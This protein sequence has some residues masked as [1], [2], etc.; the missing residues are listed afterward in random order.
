[1]AGLLL[2]SLSSCALP[3]AALLPLLL[4]CPFLPCP[5]LLC[6]KSCTPQSQDTPLYDLRKVV[7]EAYQP[8]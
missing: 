4:T 7:P 5:V 1:M 3:P 6:S 2:A 8:R